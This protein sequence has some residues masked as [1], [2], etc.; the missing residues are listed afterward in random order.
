MQTILDL[1]KQMSI[2]VPS[3][4]AGTILLTGLLDAAFNVKK[5][6]VKHLLSWL[7]ALAGAMVACAC[8][9]MDFGLGGWNYAVAAAVGLLAGAASNGVYDWK[10]VGDFID[11]FYELFGRKKF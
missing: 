4:I 8:G 2:E 11:K 9:G 5:A 6:W 10:F 3:I 1:I 7:I